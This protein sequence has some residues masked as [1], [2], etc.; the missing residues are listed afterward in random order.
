[1]GSLVV[2]VGRSFGASS[3]TCC[4]LFLLHGLEDILVRVAY[5]LLGD[6]SEW[7]TST[8]LVPSDVH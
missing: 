4:C 5:L 7:R 3:A 2:S 6:G 1:M 8:T